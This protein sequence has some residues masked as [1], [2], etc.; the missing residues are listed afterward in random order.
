MSRDCSGLHCPGCRDNPLGALAI[1][2]AAGVAVAVVAEF[3]ADLLAVAGSV[4]AL[5]LAGVAVKL[6]RLHRQGRLSLSPVVAWEPNSVRP[7][8]PAAPVT[9]RPAAALPGP[10]Q[11]HIHLHGVSPAQA[12]QEIAAIRDA[13]YRTSGQ[14]EGR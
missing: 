3:L 14:R 2:A 10:Q 12:A 4:V 7:V 13:G 8:S 1:L 11:L 5:A 9:A 6:V